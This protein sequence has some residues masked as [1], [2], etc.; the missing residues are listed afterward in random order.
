MQSMLARLVC[1]ILAAS[2]LILPFQAQAG[3]I[4]S[5]RAASAPTVTN[6]ISRGARRIWAAVTR[7]SPE[8]G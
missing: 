7:S 5:D 8:A 1:R 2:M 4:G 3:L 6:A